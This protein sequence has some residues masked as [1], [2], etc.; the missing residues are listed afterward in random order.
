ML[1]T[2]NSQVENISGRDEHA[3]LPF[4][5]WV[6]DNAKKKKN[7]KEQRICQWRTI[8][9]NFLSKEYNSEGRLPHRE[10]KHN[11]LLR[12]MRKS[13]E[14]NY[15]FF[16]CIS[17]TE[18][19]PHWIWLLGMLPEESETFHASITNGYWYYLSKQRDINFVCLWL[20]KYSC[21]LV[22]GNTWLQNVCL[23]NR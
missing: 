2:S 4:I 8:K 14:W 7:P 21:R 11:L 10:R 9:I 23:K 3:K 13:N 6:Q 18:L 19:L 5:A 1:I 17:S 16:I 15:L 20:T 22:L 12:A